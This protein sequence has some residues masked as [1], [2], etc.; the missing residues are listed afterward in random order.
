MHEPTI[1]RQ[2]NAERIV[3]FGWSRAILLQLA[4]PLVAA[5]V[6]EH[7]SFRSGGTSSIVRLH[8]TIRAMLALTFGDEAGREAALNGIRAIHTRV[9]GVLRTTTGIYPAGTR[10]SAEDPNLVLWVHATLLES[11]PLVYSRLIRE[12]TDRERDAYCADA[13]SIAIEL[14]ARPGDVPRTWTQTLTYLEGMYFSGAICVGDEARQLAAAVLSPPLAL[15]VAPAYANK[16]MTVGLLPQPLR[17][18]Y[19]FEWNSRLDRRL[20]RLVGVVRVLRTLLPRR[21]AHT[22]EQEHCDRRQRDAERG[23]H[24]DD[25]PAA[26]RVRL[27]ASSPSM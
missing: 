21:L 24:H 22:D 10:Y 18:Q 11:I 23:D 3:L 1:A 2:V 8:H 13:A 5:G 12:L 9:H 15:L 17:V 4:H 26:E 6:A 7:S 16:L 27:H 14:G 19:G 25:E 20:T